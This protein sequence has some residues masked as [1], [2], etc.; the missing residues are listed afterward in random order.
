M[1]RRAWAASN[2][3]MSLLTNID[4]L[5]AYPGILAVAICGPSN[6]LTFRGDSSNSGA[7][8][9]EQVLSVSLDMLRATGADS[10]RVMYNA[11]TIYCETHGSDVVAVAFPTGH[12]L[13]K[14]LRRMLRRMSRPE[15]RKSDRAAAVDKVLHAIEPAIREPVAVADPRLDVA[16]ADLPSGGVW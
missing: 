3:P 9:S 2:R 7:Q 6:P 11:V 14:S 4:K 16:N 1:N 13:A 8:P 5:R 10:I 15:G 12:A